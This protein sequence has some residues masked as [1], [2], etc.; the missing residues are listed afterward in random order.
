SIDFAGKKCTVLGLGISNLPLIDFLLD[1]GALICARDQNNIDLKKHSNLVSRGVKF[2]CG[3]NY[4]KDIDGDYIFRSPGIRPDIP[5]IKS[6]VEHGAVLL[7][8]MELFFM[9]CPARIFAVTGSDGK[10]TTTTLTYKL[11]EESVK[12]E[13]KDR[14]VYVGGNIGTPLLPLV[15][16]MTADDFA[17]VELSSFQLMTMTSTAFGAA[18]TNIT[19][20]HLNWHI[21]FD[22]YTGSK[23]NVCGEKTKRIVINADNDLSFALGNK[24]SAEKIVFSIDK[25]ENAFNGDFK[26]CESNGFITVN[27]DDYLSVSDIKIPGRFNVANYMC[28]IG[29]TLGFVTKEQIQR[30]AKTFGGVEHRNEFVRELDGIK[31]YNS[32]IDSSPSRTMAALSSYPTKPI[33]I[34]GGRDKHVPF[35]ELAVDIINEAKALVITGEAKDQ[36][37]S[38]MQNA[39]CG[40][41]KIIVKDDFT[42]AVAAARN[43]AKSGDIV[44]LSPACT[45]FDAFKNFEERGKKFKEIVNNF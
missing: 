7:S 30:V 16:K 39:G 11:L 29:L 27:G 2:I 40:D 41:F 21:D 6:A 34:C 15:D 1:R 36:I 19:P 37:Y 33:L 31:Y 14:H 43:I 24:S 8:E 4:L 44:L 18:I 20:N 9:L 12:D 45:S 26:I 35:D 3:P 10:T 17:V 5:E 32:S 13:K 28:A 25:C 42:D 22:E 38:A 23:Y